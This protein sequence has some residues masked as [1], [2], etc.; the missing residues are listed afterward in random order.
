MRELKESSVSDTVTGSRRT[1]DLLFRACSKSE[2][3]VW[4]ESRGR[5]HVEPMKG[6]K[7]IILN[8]H[9][10]PMPMIQWGD[11][12]QGLGLFRPWGVLTEGRRILVVGSGNRD[13]LGWAVAE[14]IGKSVFSLV[15]DEGSGKRVMEEWANRGGDEIMKVKCEMVGN[16]GHRRPVEIVLYRSRERSLALSIIIQV[17][18]CGF[19]TTQDIPH[20]HN[21][22]VFE[23]LDTSRGSSWQYELKQLKFANRRLY[24]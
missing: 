6:R 16:D 17:K 23:E 9:V 19:T 8:G 4:V 11:V 1:V 12:V 7:A 18:A 3:Y 2:G 24:E 22:D 14:T 10:R 21:I 15:D 13:V 5:L 20:P